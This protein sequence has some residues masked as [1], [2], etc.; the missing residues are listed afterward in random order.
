MDSKGET[1]ENPVVYQNSLTELKVEKRIERPEGA[2]LSSDEKSK[3]FTFT[4]SGLTEGKTYFSRK[5]TKADSSEGQDLQEGETF[6][7]TS[8]RNTFTLKDSQYVMIYGLEKGKT[9]TVKENAEEGYEVS[10]ETSG[11]KKSEGE[12]KIP[13]EKTVDTPII[14]AVNHRLGMIVIEKKTGGNKPLDGVVFELQYKEKGGDTYKPAD[15]TVC[16]N[17]SIVNPPENSGLQPGQ[18]KTGNVIVHDEEKKGC[19]LFNQLMTGYDYRIVEVSVPEG[20]NKLEKP[21]EIS[22]PYET[23]KE[24]PAGKTKPFYEMGGK[25]ILCRSNPSD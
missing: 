21:V 4:I 23:T 11:G 12:I 10:Y 14:T 16:R 7:L 18:V 15:E 17:P 24:N 22:L 25:K 6:T 1:K 19:A 5:Y 9:Y 8:E 3:E 20:Y 2:E 13:E